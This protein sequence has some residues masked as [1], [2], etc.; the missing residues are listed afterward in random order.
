MAD[1]QTRVRA[2]NRAASR[3][4]M[5]NGTGYRVVRSAC[6]PVQPS[7][8]EIGNWAITPRTRRNT[9]WQRTDQTQG[10]LGLYNC[11]TQ[12]CQGNPR[13]EGKGS[14]LKKRTKKL[15]SVWPGAGGGHRAKMDEVFLLLFVH[16]KKILSCGCASRSAS[17]RQIAGDD[18]AD[19]QSAPGLATPAGRRRAVPGRPSPSCSLDVPCTDAGC[20]KRSPPGA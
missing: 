11:A 16:K 8:S 19:A 14:F 5:G 18:T 13:E 4:R 2:A 6:L 12:H 20:V 9:G 17:L 1:A 3:R 15:L 10:A 7:R